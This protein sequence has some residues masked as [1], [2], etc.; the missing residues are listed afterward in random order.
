[1]RS[2]EGGLGFGGRN[3]CGSCRCF[4]SLFCAGVRILGV[5]EEWV[6]VCGGI[7]FF[8]GIVGEG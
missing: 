6:W 8:E 3:F 5:G 2:L 7:G 4:A 1:M